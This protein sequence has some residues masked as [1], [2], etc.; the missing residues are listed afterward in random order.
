ME[1][2]DYV[3]RHWAEQQLLHS[4]RRRDAFYASQASVVLENLWGEEVVEGTC[5][6]AQYYRLT[7][8]PLVVFEAQETRAMDYG[9]AIHAHEVQ[10][11]S[12]ARILVAEEFP[13]VIPEHN[14][15]GRGDAL[16]INPH[17]KTTPPEY[18]G[19]EIK[20]VGSPYGCITGAR[21]S[22]PA[23]KTNHLL[24]VGVYLDW[25]KQKH[26]IH[27]WQ[28]QYFS[29]ADGQRAEYT[30][31]LT[32]DAEKKISV[33]GEVTA[34]SV[35]DI[36]QRFRHLKGYLDSDEMPPRDYALMYNQETLNKMA[37][38]QQLNKKERALVKSGKPVNKGDWQC[39]YC[40][41]KKYCYPDM[42][43][44]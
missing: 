8:D 37:D 34:I 14:I 25:G 31:T 30:I 3:D 18:V 43:G 9:N 11:L 21:G 2:M 12:A 10:R 35:E 24:Q 36:Y 1:L 17:S 6:R 38:R 39:R 23:P 40:N 27:A 33:D 5:L 15:S 26:N 22:V 41:Y 29:R 13:I 20:T 32:D 4:D 19:V 28:L 7:L 16:I 42:E 44:E